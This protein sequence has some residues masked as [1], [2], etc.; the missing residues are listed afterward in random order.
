M[1]P[2]S[3][4]DRPDKGP[5]TSNPVAPA[6][7]R[8]LGVAA[9][10]VVLALLPL[11]VLAL[12]ST[13]QVTG[14]HHDAVRA[15]TG[16]R[17]VPALTRVVAA[18]TA[19]VAEQSA[20]ETLLYLR[21]S[22]FSLQLADEIL[23]VDMLGALRA[24]Q[25]D[26]G[27]ALRSVA[28]ALAVGVRAAL[29][30]V[31]PLIGRPATTGSQIDA[32]YH[33]AEMKLEQSAAATLSSVQAEILPLSGGSAAYRALVAL[34]WSYQLVK[35]GAAEAFDDTAALF[36]APAERK[37]AEMKLAQDIALF[38]E[39]GGHI[40]QSG[41]AGAAKGW[42]A[43]QSNASAQDYSTLVLDAAEGLALPYSHGV[44]YQGPGRMSLGVLTGSVSGNLTRWRIIADI[45]HQSSLVLREQ[46]AALE[47]SNDR[48]YSLWL[49]LIVVIALVTLTVAIAV[50]RS[51][52]RPLG[53]LAGT[54][55]AVVAGHL[56]IDELATNG[57]NETV[58]VADAFNSLMANLR[59]LEA[60]AQA[61][62]ECDFGNEV[63]ATPLPGRLGA[64]LQDSVH[65]LA[66]S[67]QDRE[68]LQERLA[69]E[70][71][72][73]NLTGLLNRAAAVSA[74]GQ[75]L[76]RARRRADLTAILYVDLDNFKQAN[77]LHGHPTGDHIL[78]QVADRLTGAVRS[79]DVVA[80]L[81]G[82]E[83]VVI[84]ERTAGRPE[85]ELLAERIIGTLSEPISWGAGSLTI[86]ATIGIT[87]AYADDS[88]ALELLARADLALY[89]AKQRGGNSIAV[90]DETLQQGL[91]RRDK[92]ERDLREELARGGGG[93]VLHYQPLVEMG[94]T[95]HGVEALV[96]WERP[97]EGLLLPAAF[98]PV[99]E[100]SDLIIELD[101]WVLA[102]AARQLVTWS[103]RPGL[104][105]LNVSVN[106]SGRHLVSRNLAGRIKQVLAETGVNPHQLTIEVTET[107]L[108]DD[109]TIVAAEL[110]AV[111]DLGVRVAVDDFGTGYTSLAHLHRL[112]I[113]SIK[114]DRSFIC[115]IEG[116]KEASLVRMI[117]DLAHQLGLQ[118]VSE[119][120]ETAQQL[121]ILR[122][123]GSDRLQG[124]LIAHPMPADQI[125]QW[126]AS[127][128]A[129]DQQGDG[130]LTGPLANPARVPRL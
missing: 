53:R 15:R 47:S 28:P 64:A 91:A 95:L 83:F 126:A 89:Q 1:H 93:L 81:G 19:L 66:G 101:N 18:L 29:R 67:I 113:D 55:Q 99:A 63:L 105:D 11:L 43:L 111:R 33:A 6:A 86:G 77:D 24:A 51:I 46:T 94:T 129:N 120:V 9:R 44:V 16:D 36:G 8:R 59:L 124:F 117:T 82:D 78:R 104:T 68:R 102:T 27:D 26:T 73:D 127:Y 90:W 13:P 97:G 103:G 20:A 31:H 60:K 106:V 71:T 35:V 2:H 114:I 112:P 108:L 122:D 128:R 32:S 118:T 48:E 4:G 21:S 14:I 130:T 119:G 123:L 109:L 98:I 125:P 76:A 74:L 38:A 96:R 5:A 79:G 85:A 12:A 87:I 84:A 80:R 23:H 88:D 54:A 69:H 65:V 7:R 58:V 40:G 30:T 70:A 37:A 100:A 57:P 92:I 3:H 42:A 49:A 22:G 110:E 121:E 107:V 17:E 39:A 10:L 45:V 56:D 34:D 50:A 115:E 116:L 25:A 61:L 41:V 72:H 62:A 75:A 52:S